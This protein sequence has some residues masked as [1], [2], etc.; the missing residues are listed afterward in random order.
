V[1][2]LT[3][4]DFRLVTPVHVR[5]GSVAYGV[6][7]GDAEVHLTIRAVTNIELDA[8][9]TSILDLARRVADRDELGIEVEA[10]EDFHANVNDPDTTARVRRAAEAC[11]FDVLIPDA[12]M[13]AGED[14]GLFSERFPCCMVLLGAGEDHHP[15]H[16]PHYDFPDELIPTGVQLFEQIVRQ[17]AD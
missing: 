11:G 6:S 2:D 7:A 15:I 1:R 13:P 8:L 12:G 16:N 10:L 3:A 4:P 9:Q 17:A 14:F 5:I